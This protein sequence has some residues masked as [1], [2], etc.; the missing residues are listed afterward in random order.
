MRPPF[1][2][3]VVTGF[4]V[5]AALG[6]GITAQ[7]IPVVSHLT[8]RQG[9]A[10]PNTIPAVVQA[11]RE[12]RV[13]VQLLDAPLA[14]AHGR[15]AKRLGGRLSAG[16]QR[17]YLAGLRSQHDVLAAEIR[18]L[19][20]REL[21][22]LSK[23]LN[24]IVVAIDASQAPALAALPGVSAVRPL[25]DYQL[26]LS[27]T[28]P[29]VGASAV[30]HAGVD[31]SGV[32]VAVLDTGIDYT[33]KNLGGPGTL[34]A[35]QQA[36]G[37]TTT[38]S[39][40]TTTDGLFPTAKVVNGYD[41]IGEQWPDG[42]LAPDP[43][44]IDCGPSAI[45]PP[46]L[47]GH[48]THV[49][50]IIA[51]N[52]G[53]SHRGVAPGASLIAI[54]VCGGIQLA[55]DGLAVLQGLEFAL[56]P[57]GD[58]DISDAV[59]IINLSFGRPY[60]QVQDPLVEA[61]SIASRLGV[62]VV[63][64]AGNRG[65]HPYFVSSP[66]TAPEAISVAQTQMPAAVM[67]LMEIASPADIAGEHAAAFQSWSTAQTSVIQALVQYGDAAGGNLDGCA[68]FP[69]GS[70]AGRIVLVDRGNCQLSDKA[71]NIAAGG[72]R[73]SLVG[74][75][76][77]GDPFDSGAIVYPTVGVPTYMIG[78]AAS[79]AIKSRI[80]TGVVVRL[81][82][83]NNVALVMGMVATSA[84]GP[85]YSFNSIKPDIGAPGASVSAEAGTGSGDTVFGGTSGATPLISGAAALL[86]QANPTLAPLQ[87]KARLMNTAAA[88]VQTDRFSQSGGL[89]PI[90]RIGSGEVR[91]DRAFAST[92]E[93]W[94][95]DDLTPSLSFG[96]HTIH[97][98]TNF[99]KTIEVQNSG[100]RRRT[101]SIRAG[102]RY[103]SDGA[104][105]AVDVEV[106][107]T[108]AIPPHGSGT[109]KVRLRVNPLK[110]PVWKLNGGASGGDGVQ[111]QDV[112]FDGFI[113][114]TDDR[115]TVRLPWHLLA[116]R[117][118]NVTADTD[119]VRLKNDSGAVVLRNNASS[120]AGRVEV[121]SL[122][123]TSQKIPR[124]L[125]PGAGD[126]FAVIDLKSVGARLV[127]SELGPAIQFAIHTFDTRAHPNYPAEFDIVIDTNRD[128]E[129]EYVVFNWEAVGFA[130]TGQNVVA[131]FD[132]A[133]GSV[134]EYFFAD[135]DLD[136]ANIILTAPL[137]AV[138]LNPGSAFDFSI[139]AFDNF[140]S[141]QLTDA[142]E[143]MTYTPS[144]PRFSAAGV[145]ASGV[146]VG[147]RSTLTIEAVP[148]G[149]AASPS[150]IGL[151]LMYRDGIAKH[152]ADA[153]T[154][155]PPGKGRTQ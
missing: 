130:A 17:D 139:Y 33:H 47:M 64:A 83:D 75:L 102:F 15:D 52:D 100:D 121:F 25:Y 123:G 134:A 8:V 32:R 136:S 51:G 7:D 116:H 37:T 56:D 50:D 135:T 84:R 133:A 128:G 146:P 35:Y 66:S 49:A 44:P 27:T 73:V 90:T 80:S 39:R 137:A 42:P 147:G 30:Q 144:I 94:D 40:N 120:V 104:S 70:L 38:D 1:L 97:D 54:K 98:Q 78:H 58:G 131:V 48:G 59:D 68:A 108:I 142:I 92:T 31:G 71:R 41:F 79:S 122:L 140:F 118:A 113:T 101:Y 46:C 129:P 143:G 12:I 114:L 4:A 67:N 14:V 81:D 2:V 111:L 63:A 76:E 112:E 16:Q 151:L 53:G 74:L 22:R 72:A 149:D 19:R 117:A 26:D 86:I 93:A 150:Q 57:N 99:D 43:D 23:L 91:V 109:F 125:Q 115:D 138:G 6:P 20:G 24:A 105:R 155:E 132:L 61:A 3:R 45:G 107:S 77:P 10:H 60:G 21:G 96:F 95:A 154:V 82:P 29:Y 5:A 13:V 65:D 145:P 88:N 152:E 87:V 141:F 110:L 89:A 36:Y 28:V 119:R 148:G 34:E 153:I 124:Q 103:A 106:P 127:D 85:S 69:P 18:R 62:V 9:A 11:A 55:C 126:G